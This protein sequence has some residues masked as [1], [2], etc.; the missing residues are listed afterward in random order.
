MGQPRVFAAFRCFNLSTGTSNTAATGFTVS[1]K[2]YIQMPFCGSVKAA[3]LT[4]EE[5][6]DKLTEL[7]QA[8][9]KKP[10]VTVAVQ[11][12][13]SGRIYVDGEVRTPGQLILHDV[14]MT[15]PEAL[16]RAGGITTA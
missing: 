3:G 15:L 6:R 2:G 12:Y 7:L 10:Q 14:P 9:L 13:R 4:D 5:L 16:S 8:M 11:T 1:A